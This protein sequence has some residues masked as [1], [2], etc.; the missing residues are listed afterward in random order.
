MSTTF[1]HNIFPSIFVWR[2]FFL[3]LQKTKKITIQFHHQV[4]YL[5][6]ICITELSS[7]QKTFITNFFHHNLFF[8]S[9]YCHYSHYSH[10]NHYSSFPNY[11]RRAKIN[12]IRAFPEQVLKLNQSK[13]RAFQPKNQ[14]KTEFSVSTWFIYLSCNLSY[15][16]SVDL[17]NA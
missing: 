14:S 8:I 6:N 3:S 16:F 12:K 10:Y 2:I 9:H 7:S 13:I 15:D 4:S 17:P 11:V 1:Y 5:D